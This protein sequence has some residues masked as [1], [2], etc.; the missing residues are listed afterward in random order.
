MRTRDHGENFTQLILRGYNQQEALSEMKI[1]L[2]P[3]GQT[4]QTRLVVQH[5]FLFIFYVID[6]DFLVLIKMQTPTQL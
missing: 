1:G 4:C 3:S 2:S 6:P 5:N